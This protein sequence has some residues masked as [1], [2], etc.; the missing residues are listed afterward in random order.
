M[1]KLLRPQDRI[2]LVLSGVV[3]LAEEMFPPRFYCYYDVL[4]GWVPKGYKKA[5]LFATIRRAVAAGYIEK[6]IKKGKPY[7]RLTGIGKKKLV[8]DFPIFRFA[9][10]KWDKRW[11]VVMFDV[12]EVE[13]WV[14][15]SLRTKLLELGFGMYQK[16]VYISPHTGLASDL[17]EFLTLSGLKKIVQVMVGPWLLVGDEK[18]L[19]R[20]VFKLDK[21]NK[22]YQKILDD[23]EEGR[24]VGGKKKESLIKSLRTRYLNILADDP[25]L[26]KELLP[27]DWTG[28]EA[29]RLV[30]RL[31]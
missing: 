4:R 19:A 24:G 6:V 13:R 14:R 17:A 1:A 11:V 20:K 25:F 31:K 15:D 8:R 5:N 27:D 28:E 26:P 22:A 3:D 2:L 9:K 21:I 23:W 18:V 30:A 16:S 29:R 12:A 10:K 7:F